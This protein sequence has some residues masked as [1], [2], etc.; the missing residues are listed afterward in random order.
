MEKVGFRTCLNRVREKCIKVEMVATDWHAG[1]RK[2]MRSE[3]PDIDHD[4]DVFNFAK[5]IK[6]KL[7]AKAKKMARAKKKDVE[8]LSRWI[9][10]I[11]NH[12]WW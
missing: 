7:L 8:D 11:S 2:V 9:Q 1:I 5:S 6:K 3:Y 12:L 10:A 4:F